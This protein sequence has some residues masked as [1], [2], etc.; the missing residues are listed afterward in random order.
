MRCP[1]KPKI[2][3]YC[4]FT[5]LQATSLFQLLHK[6]FAY[7]CSVLSYRRNDLNWSI[8]TWQARKL[9]LKT[10]E[11]LVCVKFSLCEIDRIPCDWLLLIA[12][13]SWCH[14]STASV[15]RKLKVLDLY[16]LPKNLD[17][18]PFLPN[19][20]NPMNGITLGRVSTDVLVVI[21]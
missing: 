4:E 14:V 13:D 6:S 3:A 19:S 18:Q 5:V 11:V 2:V 9:V 16:V 15:A 1:Q 10:K 12:V 20:W 21:L 8:H 7:S 17:L